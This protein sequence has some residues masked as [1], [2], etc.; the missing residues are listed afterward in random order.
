MKLKNI[1]VKETQKTNKKKKRKLNMQKIFNL[2]SFT[3]ILAC[4]IF[5]GGRFAKLYLDNNQEGE[6]KVLA[7]HIKEN[8]KDDKIFKEINGVHYFT[9]ENPNNYIEYSNLTWRIIKVNNDN[10][11]TIV[12]ENPITALAAGTSKGYENS[13]I[14]M[15][16][17]NQNKDYTGILEKNLNRTETYLT[18]TKTCNDT[19]DDTKNITCKK[20]IENTLIT[21]PSLNDYVNTG[22]HEGFLNSGHYYYLT[23]STKENKLWYIDEDGKV[24]TSNGSDIIG[25]KPVITIKKNTPLIDGD[26]TK[27]NPYKIESERGIFGS[28][29]KLGNDIWRIYQ[30][31]EENIKLSLNSHLSLNGNEVKYKYS[32]NGYYHNDTKQNSLAYYL[33]NTYL[34][35]LDYKDII[36]EVKYSNGVYSNI[37]KFNYID[38]LNKKIDTKVTTLSIG[39]IILNAENTNYFSTT[40]VSEDGNQIYVIRNNFE[41]YT[42]VST[43]NL[44]VVPVI[45]IKKDLLD[46]GD[47]TIQNPLEVSHE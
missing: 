35:T 45:S 27:E 37:T 42:K 10:T 11:V 3:F 8:S 25:I 47:G 4:C 34:N 14:N 2:L 6:T 20:T 21:I 15:W 44:N 1:E 9:G 32:T 43:S 36:N 33:K 39:D 18:Y 23:N 7:K 28:Y 19:I 29:V 46:I 40:G 30:I 22:G 17:N 31:D 38:V 24:G 26:G 5:Y 16:L 12:L 13:Y 41:I